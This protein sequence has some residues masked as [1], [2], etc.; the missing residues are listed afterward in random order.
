MMDRIAGGERPQGL[1]ARFYT[2]PDIFA[3]E[4]DA[5]FARTWIMVGH[6]S[7]VVEPGRL[8]TARVGDEDVIVANDKGTITGLYNVCQHRGHQLVP[9]TGPG[10]EATEVKGAITCPYHAWTYNLDG[11][12]LNARGE[13]VGEICV[14]PV[15]VATLAGFLFVNLDPAAPP[16]GDYIPGIA[17]EL[18]AIAPKAPTRVFSHRRTH[19]VRANWKI[20]VE[21]YNECYHCPNVHKTFTAGVVSP[22]SYRIT[23]RGNTI[24][25]TAEGPDPERSGYTRTDEGNAYG[26]F[27]TWP[28]SSIQCYPGQ[29]L[30]TFRWVPQAVDETLLIREWWF[31]SPTPTTEQMEVIELDWDTTVAEDFEIMDSVQRGVGSR[32]YTPGPLV[33][34]PSGV[35]SV[36]SE[37]TVPHLHGLLR[38]A[39]AGRV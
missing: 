36:H 10:G 38:N 2:D 33:T 11:S 17:D 31:D 3:A 20:A 32:G 14:P 16:L 21:N 27:F 35:A 28:V 22:G 29:V 30:N 12:L 9:P 39:L 34:R 23:P 24:H 26:S 5:I 13:D 37:D 19:L 18:L 1:D 4:M 8:I 25:H 7:Q 6:Q 15:R